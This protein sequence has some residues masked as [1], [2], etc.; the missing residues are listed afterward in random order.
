MRSFFAKALIATTLAF[1]ATKSYANKSV[2]QCRDLVKTALI[3][4]SYDTSELSAENLRVF[5]EQGVTYLNGIE[6]PSDLTPSQ[7]S[8]LEQMEQDTL[9]ISEYYLPEGIEQNPDRIREEFNRQIIYESMLHVPVI[10]QSWLRLFYGSYI[11][12]KHTAD[13]RIKKINETVGYGVYTDRDLKQG[14]F[15]GVYS[16]V[17]KTRTPEDSS[18]YSFRLDLDFQWAVDAKDKGNF[19]RFVSHS[20]NPN[21][22]AVG[23]FYKGMQYIVFV[24]N[25]YIPKGQQLFIN[26]GHGYWNARGV[27]PQE[28]NPSLLSN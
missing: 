21:V 17:V 2:S 8:T 24:A 1:T 23:I 6:L 28:M 18:D 10:D 9:A 12:K 15:L 26:Y 22:D 19:T 20:Y 14:D 25:V 11:D 27:L 3:L 5:Q 7:K 4:A 16:G 13:V